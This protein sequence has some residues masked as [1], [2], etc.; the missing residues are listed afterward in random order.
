MTYS[1]EDLILKSFF[2]DISNLFEEQFTTNSIN[3]FINN[4][5]NK[6][7]KF[8]NS[9]IS[10][11]ALIYYIFYSFFKDTSKINSADK[12]KKIFKDVD[13]SCL[14]KKMNKMPVSFFKNLRTK[15]FD[16]YSK[17]FCKPCTSK[18]KKIIAIDG[19]NT[20]DSNYNVALNMGFYDVTNGIPILLKYEGNEKRNQES[21]LSKEYISNNI[22]EFKNVILV[23]DAFYYD[24]SLFNFLIDSKIYFI[25]NGRLNCDAY[26]K[27]IPLRQM[28]KKSKII[29]EKVRNNIRLITY[30][31]EENRTVNLKRKKQ[32]KTLTVKFVENKTINLITNLPKNY[33]NKQIK[34]IYKHRWEIETFYQ[35]IKNNF[36]ISVSK[37][38]TNKEMEICNECCLTMM[39]IMKAIKN[40]KLETCNKKPKEDHK[41][42]INE[43]RIFENFKEELLENLIIKKSITIQYLKDFQKKYCLV[44]NQKNDRHY[45]R[46]SKTPHT[47]WHFKKNSDQ[48]EEKLVLESMHF[49]TVNKLDKNKKLLVN[50]FTIIDVTTEK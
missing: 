20:L 41:L 37:T 45:R 27:K 17:Y 34:N 26:N 15:V 12:I 28:D 23:L 8:Y 48:S 38:R 2:N 6:N 4:C 49:N 46:E 24:I 31:K 43:T 29:Y 42:N 35:V 14:S 32:K 21:R 30:E 13:R 19:T 7:S 10:C 39:Y 47:K 3:L 18:N 16:I 5:D 25:I 22:N 40:N 36:N 33:D 1:R 9:K 11:R 50:K 44:H